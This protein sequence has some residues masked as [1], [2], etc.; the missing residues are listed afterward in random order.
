MLASGR[1]TADEAKQAVDR[2]KFNGDAA[3]TA[4]DVLDRNADPTELGENILA[5]IRAYLAYNAVG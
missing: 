3:G 4:L 2:R 1:L 5:T